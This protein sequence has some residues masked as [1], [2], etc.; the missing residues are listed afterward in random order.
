MQSHTEPVYTYNRLH[1]R[2]LAVLAKARRGSAAGSA[3]CSAD[4]AGARYRQQ[5]LPCRH[6]VVP[7]RIM[8]SML[9][10]AKFTDLDFGQILGK[11]P[12]SKVSPSNTLQAWAD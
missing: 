8:F 11:V 3:A 10:F 12:P 2:Y 1:A 6:D 9:N 4:M 7:G 5:E